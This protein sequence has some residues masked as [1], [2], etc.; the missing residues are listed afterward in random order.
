[1]VAQWVN[2]AL[3]LSLSVYMCANERKGKLIVMN[4]NQKLGIVEN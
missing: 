3:S 4:I 2:A 1:M